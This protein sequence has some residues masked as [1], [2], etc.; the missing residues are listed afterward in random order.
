MNTNY[1]SDHLNNNNKS[2]KKKRNLINKNIFLTSNHS[3]NRNDPD[4]NNNPSI[5]PKTPPKPNHIL[6]LLMKNQE[7]KENPIIKI[8]KSSL[9]DLPTPSSISII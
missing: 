1:D 9:L 6:I 4:F 2:N 7:I 8:I 5:Q 3:N